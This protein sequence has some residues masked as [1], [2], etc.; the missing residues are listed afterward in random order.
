MGKTK[1]ELTKQ[2]LPWRIVGS[3]AGK[4]GC[5][6]SEL[7]AQEQGKDVYFQVSARD[8][9]IIPNGLINLMWVNTTV[10]QSSSDSNL[11]A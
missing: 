7:S 11:F 9:A 2:E 6:A 4:F 10:K 5:S 1:M 8:V 3:Q